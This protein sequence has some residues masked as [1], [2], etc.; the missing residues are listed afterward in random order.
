MTTMTTTNYNY[1]IPQPLHLTASGILQFLLRGTR[2]YSSGL[3]CG[4]TN[5]EYISISELQSRIY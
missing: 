4:A 1:N 5:M 2:V 3:W